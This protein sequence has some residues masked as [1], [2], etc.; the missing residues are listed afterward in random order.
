MVLARPTR[1]DGSCRKIEP[2]GRMRVPAGI[3]A[4]RER[5]AMLAGSAVRAVA[6]GRD[7]REDLGRTGPPS[8]PAADHRGQRL[9]RGE[10]AVTVHCGSRGLACAPIGSAA[11]RQDPGAMRAAIDCPLANRQIIGHLARQVFE[12]FFSGT[13]LRL[14]YEVSHNTGKRERHRVADRWLHLSVHRKGPSRALPEPLPPFGPPAPMHGGTGSGARVSAG[15]ARRS[16][17]AWRKPVWRRTASRCEVSPRKHRMPAG[18]SMRWGTRRI[19][20]G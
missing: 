7:E 9:L 11:S 13:R 17:P 18:T 15:V 3:F 2:E 16:P 6:R 5:E 12:R 8:R 10:V 1:V 14:L 20:P 4:G 19:G